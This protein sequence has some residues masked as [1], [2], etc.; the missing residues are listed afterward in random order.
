MRSLI[1]FLAAVLLALMVMRPTRV[2]IVGNATS[3]TPSTPSIS[4]TSTKETYD[5]ASFADAIA[6]VYNTP[7]P[8]PTR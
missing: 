2:E 1:L 5:L 4:K 8:T 7:T 6:K 3:T